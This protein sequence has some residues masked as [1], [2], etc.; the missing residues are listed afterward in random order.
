M[1]QVDK[2]AITEYIQACTC[3]RVVLGWHFD[4]ANGDDDNN[5]GSIDCYSTDS[6]FC[7]WCKSRS[8]SRR[9]YSN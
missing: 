3:C 8:K 7:N 6:V 1:E 2:D 5:S 4:R 9:V